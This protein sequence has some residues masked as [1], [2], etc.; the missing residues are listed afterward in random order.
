MGSRE[1]LDSCKASGFRADTTE[2]CGLGDFMRVTNFFADSHFRNK[3]T[4]SQQ[5]FI[6]QV[7]EKT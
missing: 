2:P 6:Y 5:K 1:K 4:L 3:C 7:K